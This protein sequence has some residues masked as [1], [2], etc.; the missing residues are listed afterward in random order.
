MPDN[1]FRSRDPK[2]IHQ[3]EKYGKRHQNAKKKEDV[4]DDCLKAGFY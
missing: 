1:K 4:R 2:F 3:K